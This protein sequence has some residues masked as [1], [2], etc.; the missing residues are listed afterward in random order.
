MLRFSVVVLSP[1]P[2]EGGGSFG[3]RS[4]GHPAAVLDVEKEPN[5]ANHL[6]GQA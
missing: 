1:C 6:R 4:P 3:Q 5:P 2:L